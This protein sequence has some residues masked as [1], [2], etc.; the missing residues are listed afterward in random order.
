MRPDCGGVSLDPSLRHPDKAP[1]PPH[2]GARRPSWAPRGLSVSTSSPPDPGLLE[3]W[4][5]VCSFFTSASPE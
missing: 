3:E 1:P 4:F 2:E 5:S